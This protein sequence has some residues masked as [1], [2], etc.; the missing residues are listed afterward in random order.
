LLACDV[1]TIETESD[2]A[3]TCK[4]ILTALS[5]L[6]NITVFFK[7]LDFY[8]TLTAV[9]Y[10]SLVSQPVSLLRFYNAHVV[11]YWTHTSE[12]QVQCQ[13]SAH[14][15]SSGHSGVGKSFGRS[16]L[17]FTCQY[18]SINAPHSCLIHLPLMPYRFIN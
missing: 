15:I 11:N 4:G 1:S 2:D 5:F 18:H 13:A 12:A 17:V 6:N 8:E 7:N 10:L 14:G 16:I 3:Q 9:Y